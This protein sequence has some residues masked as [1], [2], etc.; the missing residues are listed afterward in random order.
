[1]ELYMKFAEIKKQLGTNTSIKEL[2][3]I[4]ASV[5]PG[6]VKK[7]LG[8]KKNNAENIFVKIIRTKLS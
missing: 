4:I 6:D 5:G 2:K 1:M 7:Y 8:K 3:K